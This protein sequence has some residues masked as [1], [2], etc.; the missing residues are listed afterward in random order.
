MR[1]Q[2]R[3]LFHLSDCDEGKY[4]N[5]EGVNP[6]ESTETIRQTWNTHVFLSYENAT[7]IKICQYSKTEAR[8]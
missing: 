6:E 7:H 4:Q 1:A 8:V 2:K 5:R 3:L